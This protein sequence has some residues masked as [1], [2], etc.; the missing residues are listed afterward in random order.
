[1]FHKLSN[2]PYIHFKC[3][4]SKLFQQ[5]ETKQTFPKSNQSHRYKMSHS[6]CKSNPMAVGKLTTSRQVAP[7]IIF[8]HRVRFAHNTG[9]ALRCAQLLNAQGTVLVGGVAD[10]AQLPLLCFSHLTECLWCFKLKCIKKN[11]FQEMIGW[12]GYLIMTYIWCRLWPA[13]TL[14]LKMAWAGSNPVMMYNEFEHVK[15]SFLGQK[16][17]V[18]SRL[19]ALKKPCVFQWPI[20]TSGACGWRWQNSQCKSW[21]FGE[22]TSWSLFLVALEV[23]CEQPLGK[24]FE[25][26]WTVYTFLFWSNAS[27][28]VA[29]AQTYLQK[30]QMEQ[31]PSAAFP[32]MSIKEPRKLSKAITT[33]EFALRLMLGCE[34]STAWLSFLSQSNDVPWKTRWWCWRDNDDRQ[35]LGFIS[36]GDHVEHE[37]IAVFGYPYASF[38]Y[39]C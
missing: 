36:Y 38:S 5:A 2:V 30:G 39:M 10:E 32:S 13:D 24:T 37:P 3:G 15:S 8:L 26:L 20:V 22:S 27:F 6:W 9:A 33:R 7:S 21:R 31:R 28:L 17:M 18:S 23:V 19:P 25:H 12:C 29:N 34:S 35:E 16:S 11:W 1:M 4:Y 14:E